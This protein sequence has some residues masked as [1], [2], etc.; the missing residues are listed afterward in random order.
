MTA[1]KNAQLCHP[2][3]DLIARKVLGLSVKD[4]ARMLDTSLPMVRRLRQ[5]NLSSVPILLKAIEQFGVRI[6]EP[7]KSFHATAEV[8][9]S[10][11]APV[12]QQAIR[13]WTRDD[14]ILTAA[15]IV[16]D[17]IQPPDQPWA[18]P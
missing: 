1:S 8:R 9:M 14:L 3:G 6:L 16:R 18:R 11:D 2:V 4:A 10:H 17:G 7:I 13:L 15:R 5:G 12:E